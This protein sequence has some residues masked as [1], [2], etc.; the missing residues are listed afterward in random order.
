MNLKES[1]KMYM[2][3]QKGGINDTANLQKWGSIK[4]SMKSF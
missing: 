4:K 1:K 2:E 3:G